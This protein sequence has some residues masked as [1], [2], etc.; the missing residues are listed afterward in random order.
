MDIETLIG[1]LTGEERDELLAALTGTEKSSEGNLDDGEGDSGCC[2]GGRRS[3]QRRHAMM[4]E[5][6]QMCCGAG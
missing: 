3:M 4:A 6:R 2:G 1:A 5:M